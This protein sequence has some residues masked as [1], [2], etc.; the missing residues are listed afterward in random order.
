MCNWMRTEGRT[1]H[2]HHLGSQ[3]KDSRSLIL[4]SATPGPLPPWCPLQGPSVPIP[5]P[6]PGLL[7]FDV[8][9]QSECHLVLQ[10]L[11]LLPP[12]DP[13]PVCEREQG[14]A[15]WGAAQSPRQLRLDSPIPRA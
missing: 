15:S 12:G 8:A 11:N 9:L 6:I 5:I 7:A 10:L 1:P 14:G 13:W 2:H 3:R 4:R